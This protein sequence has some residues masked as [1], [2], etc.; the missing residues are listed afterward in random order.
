[1]ILY[2]N[3]IEVPNEWKYPSIY[4]EYDNSPAMYQAMNGSIPDNK[5]YHNP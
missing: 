5:N 4:D 2:V 3:N 1:M